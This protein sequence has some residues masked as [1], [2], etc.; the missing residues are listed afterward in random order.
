M[1]CRDAAEP[2]GSPGPALGV[3]QL[4]LA[5]PATGAHRADVAKLLVLRAARRRGVATALLQAVEVEA[6]SR[7]RWLLLLDT[8]TGSLAESLYEGWGWQRVGVVED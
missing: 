3:V 8:R 6:R 2:G 4:K 1:V 7:G 5:A